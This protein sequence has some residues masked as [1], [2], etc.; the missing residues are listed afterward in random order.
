MGFQTGSDNER[1]EELEKQYDDIID[2]QLNSVGGNEAISID[3][4][5]GQRNDASGDAGGIRS[6]QPIIH[7]ITEDDESGTPTGVFDKIN[8]ISSMII[9]DHTSTPM[10]LRFIQG[11][12]KD[13]SKIKITVKKDKVLVIKSGGNI[14][15]SVD[16]TI[17]DTEFYILVK[18]SEAETGITGGAYKILKVGTAGGAGYNTIQ[19]EGVSLTQRTIMNFIGATVTAVDNPGN[20]RTDITIVAGT[21]GLLSDLTINVSK[22]WAGEA[23]TNLGG[24][25]MTGDIDVNTQDIIN[26]D[27]SEYVV[28]S[29]AISAAADSVILLNSSNQFQFNTAQINDI[30]FSLEN[31]AA[32]AIDH[33]GS[34]LTRSLSILSDS[35][36]TNSIA[37]LN[38]TKNFATSISLQ[39]IGQIGFNAANDAGGGILEYAAIVGKIEDATAGAIDGSLRLEA[40]INDSIFPFLIIN[41]GG[42]GEV[43]LFRDFNVNTQNILN[44]DQSRYIVD[45]GA[46]SSNTD[47]VI[48]LNS[49]SQ[50]QFNTDEINQFV[51]SLSNNSAFVIEQEVGVSDNRIFTFSSDTT[52]S[53]SVTF[54]RIIKSILN[55][56][57]DSL[58]GSLEFFAGDSAAT[59]L[60]IYSS[61]N[62]FIED[63]TSTSKDGT[64]IFDVII[65]NTLTPIMQFNRA[66]EGGV[67]IFGKLDIGGNFMDLAE[68]ATPANPVA[69]DGRFYVRDDGGVTTPFFLDSSGTETSM[70]AGGGASNQIVAGDSNLT[71]VDGVGFTWVLDGGT[72]ATMTTEFL[73]GLDLDLDSNDI[74]NPANIILANGFQIQNT[75]ASIT[76]LNVPSG[77]DLIFAESGTEV[78]RYDGGNNNW[79]FNPVNDVQLSPDTD[80]DLTPGG[81]IIMNPTGDIR[82]FDD[83]DMDGTNTIDMGTSASVP[84]GSATG[85]F[86]IKLNGVTKLVKF[87]DP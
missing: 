22:D 16:I 12:A 69:N 24:I 49:N 32:V 27:R 47:T 17:L 50:F 60:S 35:T 6:N 70:I 34:A 42:S 40:T 63:N 7:N 15:T 3:A 51:F 56:P 83:L 8:L 82:V 61:I 72:I 11:P 84:P 80:V 21:A 39:E 28:D 9:V 62:T 67:N 30:I 5:L 25:T 20:T 19:E 43:K 48:L 85:A 68:I 38:I 18:H 36:N 87:Y 26:I 13:G 79:I 2:S 59:A 71:V 86:Q 54:L 57:D 64:V 81:D 78:A 53:N 66:S 37:V 45:S 41:D 73:L 10:D 29:G 65:N 31:I 44:I 52:N 75:S 33:D 58:I 77:E 55:P 23:I 4:T 74:L 14:L 76:T 1:I 46:V